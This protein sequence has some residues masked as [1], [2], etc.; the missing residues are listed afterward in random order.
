MFEIIASIIKRRRKTKRQGERW[1]RTEG[2][3]DG[4]TGG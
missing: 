2:Q 4:K 1:T 3:K